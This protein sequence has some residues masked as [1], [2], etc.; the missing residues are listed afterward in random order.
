MRFE[1]RHVLGLV[2][3]GQQA[4]VNAGVKGLDSAVHHLGESGQ[5]GNRMR[6]E[7]GIRER[8]KGVAGRIELEAETVEPAREPR[9]PALVTD[10]QQG[11]GQ[12]LPPTIGWPREE[13]CARLR[14]FARAGPPP[15]RLSRPGPA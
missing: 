10:R 4:G 3:P 6:I 7:R 8:L 11:S 13:S 14:G 9:Q 12:V 1:S 5:V 15:Y 2:A